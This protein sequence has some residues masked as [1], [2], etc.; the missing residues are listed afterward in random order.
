MISKI[1]NSNEK[2][3]AFYL[4]LVVF[5]LLVEFSRGIFA[6][7][8]LAIKSLE[9]QGYSNVEVTNMDWFFVGFRGC[10]MGDAAKITTNA[11]N[12]AG[13]QTEIFVCTGWPFK[14]A[15]IRTN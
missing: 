6:D 2:K 15:T 7:I 9:K 11:T 5:I 1:F 4:F 3:L 8:N 13:K 12:P 14:G 10:D